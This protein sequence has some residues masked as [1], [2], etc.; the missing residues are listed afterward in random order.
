[1]LAMPR[2][3]KKN[4]QTPSSKDLNPTISRKWVCVELS[5]TGEK[6]KN[7]D[8]VVRSARRI[9][10]NSKVEVFIPAISQQVRDESSVLS[11]MEGYIFIE[12]SSNLIYTRLQET[13][14]FK[15]ILM[16]QVF[17]GRRRIK[18]LSLLRDKDLSVMRDGVETLNKGDFRS[19]EAIKIIKGNYKN[20][21]AEIVQIYEDGKT[22][23]VYVG[24]RS[25][26]ILLDFPASYM[27]RV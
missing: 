9:L 23:Q 6:E 18:E 11:F 16:R 3:Q 27:V 1:M 10:K 22:I 12:H 21:E 14:Y 8:L 2:S 13:T 15:S 7:L 17:D 26:K 25:K 20:L 4:S 24:L 5:L 19:G